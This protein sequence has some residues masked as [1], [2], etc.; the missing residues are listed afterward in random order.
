VTPKAEST[1]LSIFY[2]IFSSIDKGTGGFNPAAGEFSAVLRCTWMIITFC[3]QV[4]MFQTG[5]SLVPA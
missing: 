1:V 4:E 2:R 3:S 5:D